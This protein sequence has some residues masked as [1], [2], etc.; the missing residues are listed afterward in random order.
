MDEKK[1]AFWKIK[2]LIALPVLIILVFL[3]WPREYG[4]TDP[5]I[6]RN[7]IR[8][9]MDFPGEIQIYHIKDV[10]VQDGMET[11]RAVIFNDDGD[12]IHID[13]REQQY[14]IHWY[15]LNADGD[16]ELYWGEDGVSGGWMC[17]GVYH[18]PDL[19][20]HGYEDTY[21]LYYV[22]DPEIK[23]ILLKFNYKIG[24]ENGEIKTQTE[25]ASVKADHAPELICIPSYLSHPFRPEIYDDPSFNER[26]CTITLSAFDA[27]G[28]L[29]YGD[30]AKEIDFNL[31]NIYRV[32]KY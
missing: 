29:L 13:W 21:N 5:A 27:E 14:R 24:K 17:Q 6:F 18:F 30:M 25:Y 15:Q 4:N 23:E 7:I 12:D 28:N 26:G 19:T 22:T 31:H 10:M 8:E 16:Y 3:C 9:T 11:M 20:M 2:L 1:N 32:E